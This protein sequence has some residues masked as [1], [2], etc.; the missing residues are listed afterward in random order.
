MLR[1]GYIHLTPDN[2][3]CIV[4]KIHKGDGF[5]YLHLD[6]GRQNICIFLFKEYRE[7]KL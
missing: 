3:S 2:A 5:C 1:K 4:D 6:G 7:E